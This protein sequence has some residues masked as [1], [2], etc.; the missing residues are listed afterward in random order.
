MVNFLILLASSFIAGV[1]AV[2]SPPIS[3]PLRSPI[4][5]VDPANF[6]PVP[7]GSTVSQVG[8][9][10]HVSSG[11]GTLLEVIPITATKTETAKVPRQTSGP[12]WLAWGQWVAPDTQAIKTF[13][14]VFTVPPPPKRYQG[15]Y[16]FLFNALI[17]RASGAI[18]QPVLQV[19][20]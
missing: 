14:T 5:D 15:Q 18:I 12:G 2:P 16:M 7:H 6:H 3:T 9:N 4:G 1:A 17:P 11:N 10:I 13:T 20:G 19:R 8:D